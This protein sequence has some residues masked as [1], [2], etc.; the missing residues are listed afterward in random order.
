M[1]GSCGNTENMT[2]NENEFDQ[3]N[4]KKP[5]IPKRDENTIKKSN[6]HKDSDKFKDMEL[7][8]NTKN[9]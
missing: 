6:S 9:F 7:Y 4:K 8:G 2:I 3:N 1:G 5:I